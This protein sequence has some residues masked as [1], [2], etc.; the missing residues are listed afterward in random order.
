[1]TL[2][3]TSVPGTNLCATATP[4]TI[5][6]TP[7]TTYS[8]STG[9]LT[10]PNCVTPAGAV[11][12][13]ASG[14]LT[15]RIFDSTG[16]Q[17][18][19]TL[20]GTSSIGANPP[21]TSYLCTITAITAGTYSATADFQG[22]S[23]YNMKS[24]A[25]ITFQIAKGNPGS[26]TVIGAPH[27]SIFGSPITFIA[28]VTGINNAVPPS[29]VLTWN[30]NAA[31][32]VLTSCPVVA[33][34]TTS[35]S[36]T[37]YT[38]DVPVSIPGDYSAT[39]TLSADSN[40]NSVGPSSAATVTISKII[41]TITL[42]HSSAPTAGGQVLFTAYV[43]GVS[44]ATPTGSFIWK[45]VTGT[46]ST[47]TCAPTPV[48]T[49]LPGALAFGCTEQLPSVGSY[50][51]Q[52]SY[53]G[54]A[55]YTALDSPSDQVDISS[56]SLQYLR[57]T[58]GGITNLRAVQGLDNLRDHVIL[59]WD[60]L[61]SASSYMVQVGSSR[62]TLNPVVCADSSSNTCTVTGLVSGNTYYFWV[63]GYGLGGQ[64]VPATTS[65]T[66][67]V[68][69]APP[70]QPST[71]PVVFVPPAPT[72]TGGLPAAT[73]SFPLAAP[74]IQGV[75][76]ISSVT[77]T[78]ANTKDPLRTAYRVDYSADG[79]TWIK[80]SA[81]PP[82]ATSAVVSNLANG[83]ADVFRL[84]P[85]GEAGDG[86][87]STASV[88]PGVA[89]QP[90]INLTAQSGDSQV[91]LSWLPPTDTG[92]LKVNN[93]VIEQST[94]GTTWTVASSVSGISSQ[95][96]IQGLT[97]FTN[98]TF[99]VSA[100]TN[101]G[102]G[103][104]AVLAA[105]TSALPSAPLALHLVSTALQ[106]LTVGWSL[107][108]GVTTSAV[109]G[110]KVEQSIDGSNWITSS[111]APAAA[112]SAVLFGLISGT[113]YEIRVTPITGTGV[114]SSSVLL[115]TPGSAPST[116]TGLSAVAG[117]KK[118]TLVFTPPT[119]NGGF[120]ID[121]YQVQ[122]AKSPS[123]PWSIAIVNSGSSIPRIVVSNLSND[124]T[125]FFRVAAVNQVGTGNFSNAISGT[126]QPAAAAP[127]VQ[128]FVLSPTTVNMAWAPPTG[129]TSKLLTGY[130]IETSPDG[131]IW[132]LVKALS[133]ST[134]TFGFVR[135][136]AAFLVRVRGVTAIGP[137][138][139]TLGV[140]VPGTSPGALPI[141]PSGKPTAKV[142]P[143][144]SKKP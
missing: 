62:T 14:T 3:T 135:R 78:W 12:S 74:Q 103:I 118:V 29:G 130:L 30:I 64:G 27:S 93:Y 100:V 102:K 37:T 85:V 1:M 139:P 52:G 34:A 109:T 116:V 8:C 94:D 7:T 120:S 65:L 126:P 98:Y 20:P 82:A 91:N 137:G 44:T 17:I 21:T 87:S 119:V 127:I 112:Q 84:T 68:Y 47:S 15:W 99:R 31:G 80:G 104:P 45:P 51:V 48:P 24:S 142:K 54:D 36:T 111:T 81:L 88:T 32:S 23:S 50:I 33:P 138:V 90:P 129:T 128:S 18:S 60:N 79:Q 41:P 59:T 26:I 72:S 96:N 28:T 123:G 115:A 2:D 140:R 113:T 143:V 11:P 39:V 76:A 69:V 77:L 9:I 67:P 134:R 141:T 56:T 63:N 101:F 106:S 122:S 131:A 6:A 55:I 132:T 71:P 46:G 25:P 97:N 16:T 107:P 110:F 125:Y 83:V 61:T 10:G 121:Y 35:G 144:P 43:T 108:S 92:G 42:V 124:T 73:V 114:G 57:V 133:L 89:S 66:L 4:S 49:T 105:N 136:S 70:P 5:L 53:S 13:T 40:Y 86:V 75:G 22:D 95:V 58:L 117:D 38:C 19:C